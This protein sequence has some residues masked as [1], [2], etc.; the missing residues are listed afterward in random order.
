VKRALLIG[1]LLT[2]CGQGRDV[3]LGDGPPCPAG[4]SI[5]EDT[6][7]LLGDAVG[8][9]RAAKGGLGGCL[10]HV[11]TLTDAG[12]GSLRE[13]LERPEPLWIVFD[14]SGTIELSTNIIVANNKTI[15]GRGRAVTLHNGGLIIEARSEVVV[16]NLSFDGSGLDPVT[17]PSTD[18]ISLLSGSHDVWIDH[19]NFSAFPDGSVDIT[20][21]STDVTVSWSTFQNQSKVMLV[22]SN[23][24][25][26]ADTVIRVTVHHNWFVQTDM[27]HPRLRFGKAH[28]FN[29]FHDRWGL[30]GIAV[31]MNGEV[32]S[33]NNIFAA[34]THPEAL[35]ITAG[36]DPTPG[37]ARSTG[38]W[39]LN[40]AVVEQA[41]PDVVFNPATYYAYQA[42]PAD[43][44]LRSSIMANAG[45]R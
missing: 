8:F 20:Q 28:T 7:A 16:E 17:Y 25:A 11:T 29:N 37:L 41:Q 34:D 33:E 45:P 22:S 19:C 23:A 30:A 38:D 43:D 5:P 14:V 44:A 2:A 1:F 32:A 3:L 18:A 27:Y 21:A 31:A 6:S 10:Y 13:G 42:A 40:G 36:T 35:L 4:M 15:D 9:G 26:T 24:E 12:T 39:L